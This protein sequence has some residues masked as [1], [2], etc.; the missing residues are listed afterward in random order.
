MEIQHDASEA[1]A[2]LHGWDSSRRY[3]NVIEM[4]ARLGQKAKR[5]VEVIT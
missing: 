2:L 3:D 1:I 5:L 4:F